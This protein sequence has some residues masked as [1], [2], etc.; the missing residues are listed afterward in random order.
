MKTLTLQQKADIVQETLCKL[1]PDPKIALNFS[2]NLELLIAVILSA[3]CTD[4]KVNEV[5]AKLFKK[6]PTLEDYAKADF[7]EF[8]QDI[9]STGFYKN[10]AKNVLGTVAK[11][12][13]EFGGKVPNTMEKLLTLPGVARKTANV[14]MAEAFGKNEGVIVDTHVT[15]LANKYGLTTQKD[16]VKIEQDLMKL[17]PQ[18]DWRRFSLGLVLYGREYSPA[19]KV[20]S[21]ED[22]ISQALLAAA[23]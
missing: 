20:T 19:H 5:T 23:A 2:N 13:S 6:Y 1:Y 15:R 16:P 10:K 17:I 11:I 7:D 18:P 12:K 4:K 9:R 22:P 21:T 14:I 8:S 3:Q